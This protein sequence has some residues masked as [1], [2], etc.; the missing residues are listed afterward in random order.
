VLV[1]GEPVKK[2]SSSSSKQLVLAAD[3]FVHLFIR[4]NHPS[5]NMCI[6]TITEFSPIGL[7]EHQI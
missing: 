4:I 7:H 6:V 5:R 3:Y 1:L 2:N